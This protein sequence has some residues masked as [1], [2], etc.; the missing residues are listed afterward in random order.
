MAIV[1]KKSSNPN[2]PQ[3]H[4]GKRKSDTTEL[5]KVGRIDKAV[6]VAGTNRASQKTNA[7]FPG[8]KITRSTDKS[9][10]GNSY[11]NRR[12]QENLK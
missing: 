9:D 2:V 1:I 7:K 3:P 10:G 12:S 6:G 4:H 5:G 11:I 8:P